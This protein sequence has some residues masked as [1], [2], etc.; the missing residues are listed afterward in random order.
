VAVISIVVATRDLSKEKGI[1]ANLNGCGSE[2]IIVS[3][4]NPSL[5]RNE[6]VR[7]AKNGI[8][9]FADDDSCVPKDVFLKAEIALENDKTISILGGPSLTPAGD[10]FIQKTFGAVFA[11]PWASGKSSA[12]YRRAGAKR[13]TDEKELILCNLFIRR[14]VFEKTGPFKEEL[15]PNEENDLLNRAQ[16][17]GF[18]LIYDPDIYVRRSQ[19]KTY[20]DFIRQCF[21]YGRGRAEQVL[22]GF[23]KND[24]INTVP[25]FFV[26]YLI[27]LSLT[28]PALEELMPLIIYLAGT[29]F[30]SFREAGA[31]GTKRSVP[32]IFMNFILLHIMYGAGFLFGIFRG[33]V[34]RNKKV[35]NKIEV[36][37]VS[38]GN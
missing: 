21:T 34:I 9:Y 18:S 26:L 1:T 31:T 27:Y 11:S 5:Q 37:I 23:N 30:F 29:A 28:G 35:D 22:G 2:L 14:E 33:I 12:R 17:L 19:R 3:G 25:A 16:A 6:G 38:I 36:K 20:W 7:L 4:R 24:I 32:V 8:I 10:S 15:Y 13:A